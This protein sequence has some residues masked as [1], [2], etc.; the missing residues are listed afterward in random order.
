MLPLKESLSA[1]LLHTEVLKGI[2]GLLKLALIFHKDS[3]E[4]ALHFL[5]HHCRHFSR[6]L[7]ITF[8]S[9]ILVD[10]IEAHI[11]Q[12]V[13]VFHAHVNVE[14]AYYYVFWSQ[15]TAIPTCINYVILSYFAY[16]LCYLGSD[17]FLTNA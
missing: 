7:C 15:I 5:R 16:L 10:A 2:L 3:N 12:W 11:A 4:V 17:T 14:F 13:F 1:Y 8:V 6:R 9:I